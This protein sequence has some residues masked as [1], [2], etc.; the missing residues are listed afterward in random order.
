MSATITWKPVKPGKTLSVGKSTSSF[1]E[2]MCRAFGDGYT[3]NLQEQHIPILKG[4]YAATN[5]LA[6]DE[7]AE[8]IEKFGE[9][10][11]DVSY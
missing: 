10:S 1:I 11:V 5:E 4:L 7:L 3:W 8:F 6:Y 9:I 2:A